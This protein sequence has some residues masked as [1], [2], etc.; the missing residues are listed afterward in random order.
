MRVLILVIAGF[1]A[2][3]FVSAAVFVLLSAVG[4]IPRFVWKFH[5]ARKLC[6]FEEMILF[7]AVAGGLGT[8]YEK[9]LLG[10][11][12]QKAW[13]WIEMTFPLLTASGERILL[14]IYGLF[15]GIFVG[16]VAVTIA[17]ILGSIPIFLLR[18]R[19]R[20]GLSVP[21]YALALGK[22]IGSILYFFSR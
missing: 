5:I 6:L 4:M 2:G 10:F 8:I 19:L 18:I 12:M 3:A 17:E 20:Q 1:S 14:I 15:A 22:M 11:R 13:Q 16:C 21:V 9:E 7:G